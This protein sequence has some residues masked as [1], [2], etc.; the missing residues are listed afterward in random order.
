MGGRN[1]V[2]LT[3]GVRLKVGVTLGKKEVSVTE[4][5]GKLQVEVGETKG[6]KVGVA[7]IVSVFVGVGISGPFPGDSAIASQ[8]RQ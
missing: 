8:P 2:R 6:L 5:V 1:G 7:V 3:V 4:K